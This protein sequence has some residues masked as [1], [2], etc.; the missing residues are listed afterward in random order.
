[1]I[2]DYRKGEKLYVV[3]EGAK[4]RRVTLTYFLGVCPQ[5]GRYFTVSP[6]GTV[7]RG[8]TGERYFKLEADAAAMIN[9]TK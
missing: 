7:Y 1:M 5:T 2:T 6:R 8:Y 4:E 3:V 9:N